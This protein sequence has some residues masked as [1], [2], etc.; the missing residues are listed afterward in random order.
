MFSITLPTVF[1]VLIVAVYLY[2]RK[3]FSYWQR[4]GIPYL[5]PKFP[6]GNFPNAILQRTTFSEEL[7]NVYHKSN[8]P[9]LGIFT[10]LKPSILVR[11]TRII[12]DILK[13]NFSSFNHRGWYGNEKIDPMAGN[14]LLMNG[15][16]WR[17]MKNVFSPAFTIG[18]LKGEWSAMF[19]VIN[20]CGVSLNKF[21]DKYADSDETVEMREVAACYTTNVI[22]SVAFGL[23]VDCLADERSD[24]RKYGHMFFNASFKNIIR[25]NLAIMNPAF[26]KFLRLRF[27]DKE[28]NDFFVETVRQNLEYRQKNNIARKDFFQML[29]QLRTTGKIQEDGADWHT[30]GTANAERLTLEQMAAQAF[31][32][33]IG[34]FYQINIRIRHFI[35]KLHLGGY[36][37][38]STTISFCLY[39]LAKNPI[40]QQRAYDE[41]VQV[42]TAYNGEISFESLNDM[43]FIESCIDETLRMHPPFGVLTRQCTQNYKLPNSNAIIEK[44]TMIMLSV[45]GLQSDPKYYKNPEEFTPD[46]F[47][48]AAVADKTFFNMPILTFGQG[49]RVCMGAQMGKLQVKIAIVHLLQRYVFELGSVHVDKKLKFH[50]KSLVKFAI[51]GINLKIKSR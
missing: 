6:F 4:I 49:P 20:G 36:E 44:G 29:I 38:S 46:R 11:D 42:L 7:Q 13:T 16:K 43:K 10:T 33:F 2:V 51:G 30:D 25:A 19:D 47:S 23:D 37:S 45:A 15:V 5:K 26:A 14:I 48:A 1:L 9:V 31:F 3:I 24:I 22:S 18:K 17:Q 27:A 40:L 50:P 41:I 28:V 32:F 12:Q 39:E 21:I 35:L 8:E 34:K